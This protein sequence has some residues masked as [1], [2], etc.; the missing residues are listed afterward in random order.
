MNSV[1]RESTRCIV[2][3]SIFKFQNMYTKFKNA[4]FFSFSLF[5]PKDPR[6]LISFKL[7]VSFG[8]RQISVLYKQQTKAFKSLETTF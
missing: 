6:S 2:F 1:G 3:Q 8:L 5:S 4:A 7:Q